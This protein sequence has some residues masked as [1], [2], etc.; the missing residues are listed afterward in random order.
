MNTN[1]VV[2]LLKNKV[3]YDL[4]PFSHLDYKDHLS[5]IVWI[6]GCPLRCAY[7]YNKDIVF[8]KYA[9]YCFND[10][11]NFLDSRKNL[12]DSVVLSGGEATSVDLIYFCKEIKKKNFKIK[13]DTNGLNFSQIKKLIDLNLL[14]YIA[15][16]FKAPR[17]KFKLLT[18]AKAS[19]FDSLEQTVKFLVK[20]CFDFE[21]RTTVHRDLLD[22]NDINN[23]ID[24]LI[25]I[26]YKGEYF[27][28]NFLETEYNIG[29]I[30]NSKQILDLD[31]IQDTNG[32]IIV[33][34]RNF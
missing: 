7:C 18:K 26:N 9:K 27:L 34:Y 31:K 23:M 32:K 33:K 6:A 22:E 1:N 10:I 21:I 5:C 29:N 8:A 19:Y 14:D 11:L 17:D 24:Y 25:K 30:K 4:T 2:S 13:L 15:L 28:Q 12:L 3:V 16:D 20:K